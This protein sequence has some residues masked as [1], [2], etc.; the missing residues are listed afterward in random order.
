MQII[1]KKE[2]FANACSKLGEKEKSHEVF[3]TVEEYVCS[4]YGFKCD[5][6]INEVSNKKN[7]WRKIETEICRTTSRLH[8]TIRSKQISTV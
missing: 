1:I 8:K 2:K 6:N 5:S 4:V 3:L 7:V